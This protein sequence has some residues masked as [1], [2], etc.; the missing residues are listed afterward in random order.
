MSSRDDRKHA[1]TG[2]NTARE[3]TW[4][5]SCLGP[6]TNENRECDFC[7]DFVRA[8]GRLTTRP[9]GRRVV[10]TP[11]RRRN[12]DIFDLRP[13]AKV[14]CPVSCGTCCS[15]WHQV[16]ELARKDVLEA[17][18]NAFT[19][20]GAL[21][22]HMTAVGCGLSLEEKPLSCSTF[23]CNLGAWVHGGKLP[24]EDAKRL[25]HAA[26][27]H[28]LEASK[29]YAAANGDVEKAVQCAEDAVARMRVKA[30]T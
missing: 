18:R 2:P 15:V 23:L 30:G 3:E 9:Q 8:F 12:F 26:D 17:S 16:K 7:A 29:A 28:P 11:L 5:L 10:L 14:Q 6:T 22:P 19:K 25:Y 4:C 24:I 13:E 20:R 21:C 27:G 1:V